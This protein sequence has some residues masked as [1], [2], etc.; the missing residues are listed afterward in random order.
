M[1]EILK[2]K[3]LIIGAILIIILGGGFYLYNLNNDDVSIVNNT[4]KIE[5]EEDEIDKKEQDNNIVVHVAGEVK[6]PGIVRLEE[7]SRLE[8]AINKA[9]G[10]TDNADIS[11]INLAYIIEDGIKIKI[12]S[13]YETEIADSYIIEGIEEGKEINKDKNNKI[14]IN[15]AT[16]EELETLDGIGASLAL[17]II[18]Y[19]EKNGKFKNMEDIKNVTGIGDSKYDA[20]KD[21]IKV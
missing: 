2:E 9:G 17:R 19:R 1:I 18:E 14:N 6:K 16:K 11:N 12:P 7:G 5:S 10:L 21:N 20:I 13:I 8:D 4:E 15:T 3:K